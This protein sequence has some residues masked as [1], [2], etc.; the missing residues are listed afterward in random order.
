MHD[1]IL[2]IHIKINMKWG[3]IQQGTFYRLFLNEFNSE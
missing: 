2:H 3:Y 1:N